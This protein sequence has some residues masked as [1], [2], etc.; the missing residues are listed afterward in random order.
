[1]DIT[2]YQFRGIPIF[3]YGMIG[4]TTLVLAYATLLDD[5]DEKDQTEASSNETEP[6]SGQAT[7][8]PNPEESNEPSAEEPPA[9]QGA[10]LRHKR[11]STQS[12][13]KKRRKSKKRNA[14]Q[15]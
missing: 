15:N 11:A 3:I 12:N 10:G 13:K 8:E 7:D 9:T 6:E 14:K 1:M 4:V 2:D 5:G